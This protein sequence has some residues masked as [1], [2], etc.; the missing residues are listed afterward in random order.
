[1]CY[2][3]SNL[4]I[5]LYSF[6]AITNIVSYWFFPSFQMKQYLTGIVNG[7]FRFPE[8]YNY[9]SGEENVWTVTESR[10]FSDGEDIRAV[11]ETM[12]W[13]RKWV[14]CFS[15]RHTGTELTA[16][17]S[18]GRWSGIYFLVELSVQWKA[19]HSEFPSG[20]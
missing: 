7:L 11:W 13:F 16:F 9:S 18:L 6:R 10:R 14:L 4:H 3:F 8:V 15:D 17:H 20:G 19:H 12:S 2:H 1:M 5:H